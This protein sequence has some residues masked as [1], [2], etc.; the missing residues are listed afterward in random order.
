MVTQ[1][2]RRKS[3]EIGYNYLYTAFTFTPHNTG[4]IYV[5]K[6]LQRDVFLRTGGLGYSAQEPRGGGHEYSGN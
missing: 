6:I 1:I 3:R 4:T 2:C 5:F